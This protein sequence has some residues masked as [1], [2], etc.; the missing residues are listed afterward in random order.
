M[1]QSI[2]DHLNGGNSVTATF[3][4]QVDGA[5]LGYWRTIR[6]GELIEVDEFGI[7]FSW[8]LITKKKTAV[9]WS[10]IQSIDFDR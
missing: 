2:L 6:P 4:R 7:V 1:K 8:G 3:I 10:N 9:P 5:P